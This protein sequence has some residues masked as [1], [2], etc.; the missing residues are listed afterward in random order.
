MSY[1]K[2]SLRVRKTTAAPK[3]L[4]LDLELVGERLLLKELS[5]KPK[6]STSSGPTFIVPKSSAIENSIQCIVVQS[7][8]EGS[9]LQIG[10]IVLIEKSNEYPSVN[11]ENTT[12]YFCQLKN[13]LAKV[14]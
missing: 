11:I 3:E 6:E 4:K 14:N 1:I 9:T 13:I 12:H 5:L 7:S 8:I 2:H 10:D